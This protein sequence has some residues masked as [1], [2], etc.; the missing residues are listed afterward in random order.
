MENE[1]PENGPGLMPILL[2]AV[3][4]MAL[5]WFLVND[6]KK[7]QKDNGND[8][9]IGTDIT[10]PTNTDNIDGDNVWNGI[11]TNED[12]TTFKIFQK[13]NTEALINGQGSSF[14]SLPAVIVDNKL[15]AEDYEL[16]IDNNVL[17]V[18]S[19]N[20][21]SITSLIGTYTKQGDYTK[22][23]YY[24]DNIGNIDYINNTTWNGIYKL[25][26]LIAKIY[27]IS[28]TEVKVDINGVV[29]GISVLF[30]N[31]FTVTDNKL[32]YQDNFFNINTNIT[33]EKQN[34]NLVIS[35]GSDDLDST[36]NKVIGTYTFDRL[37]TIDDIINN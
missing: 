36:A 17:N 28:D 3:I 35:G 10:I 34:E 31:T 33:I 30:T 6:G 12:G 11:Y 13:S 2:V 37:I 1:L 8:N 9:Q 32:L 4:L 26:E 15:I 7:T 21:D 19:S 20:D 22:E 18:N 14:L 27:Q 16:T 5:I 23:E 29:D 25:N 24:S